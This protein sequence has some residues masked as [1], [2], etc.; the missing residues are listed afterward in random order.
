VCVAGGSS[1][2]YCCRP[3]T[4]SCQGGI[5]TGDDDGCG[6]VLDCPVCPPR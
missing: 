4:C 6:G 3:R 1:S 2:S 5:G